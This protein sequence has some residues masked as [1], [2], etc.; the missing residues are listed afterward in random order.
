ML[1]RFEE[2]AEKFLL[3]TTIFVSLFFLIPLLLWVLNGIYQDP[4]WKPILDTVSLATDVIG[5][6]AIVLSFVY[7]L[8]FGRQQVVTDDT[9]ERVILRVLERTGQVPP[10]AELEEATASEF[11]E[12]TTA[13][14]ESGF[15]LTL[16]IINHAFTDLQDGKPWETIARLRQAFDVFYQSVFERIG[17]PVDSRGRF[18]TSMRAEQ[19]LMRERIL[20]KEAHVI[21]MEFRQIANRVIHTSYDPP[22]E[23]AEWAILITNRVIQIVLGNLKERSYVSEALF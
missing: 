21:S 2:R 18:I 13:L 19:L 12:V 14:G 17:K 10:D 9:I 7:Y 3:V 15:P 20:S 8:T 11:T 16:Q 23:V 4:S 22:Q 6:I 1:F 5:F